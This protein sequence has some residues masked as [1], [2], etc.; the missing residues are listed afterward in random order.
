LLGPR[1]S[2]KTTLVKEFLASTTKNVA[3]YRGDEVR[4]QT[5][6]SVPSSDKLAPLI[7][8]NDVLVIDEAQMIPGIGKSLK[9]LVDT[10]PDL[11]IIATGSSAFEL[12][13]QT[14]E[15]LTGRKRTRQ[16]LPIAL[17]EYF[18]RSRTPQADLSETL[19]NLLVYGMYP[20]VL[21]TQCE[22]E[23]S[24]FLRELVDSYLLK[25]ILAFQEVKSP[26][27]LL[28]LLNLIAYQIGGEVSLSE[29]GSSLGIDRKTVEKY[30]DLLEKTYVI[31]RVGGYSRNLRSEIT[32]MAKYYFYDNGVRNVL[33]N[34]FN[35]LDIRNDIGQLWENFVVSERQKTRLYYGPAANQYFWRTWKGSEIDLIEE[36]DGT[37]YG[38]EMKW[39]TK[40]RQPTPPKE[41][42]EAYPGTSEW[43]VITPENLYD[44]VKP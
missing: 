25:D 26:R 16:L 37:L 32:K 39:S 42:Q 31:F 41:W 20:N 18:G 14:G 2:G 13:G 7:G 24:D 29:L 35:P 11:S 4:V 34:N 27:I 21:T 43:Q 17:H 15:P 30:L 6:F 10:R 22:A 9:L 44:F 3:F 33:I 1:R 40:K 5:N 38:Y 12:A 8:G 19:P 36:R 28:Q 23:K